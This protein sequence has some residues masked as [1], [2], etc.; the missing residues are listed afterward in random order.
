MSD[1]EQLDWAK[2]KKHLETVERNYNELIGVPGVNVSL[3]IDFVIQP[4]RAR[5]NRGER[6]QELYMEIME[7]E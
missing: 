6:T 4:I 2:A 1:I 3:A 5:F 7:L